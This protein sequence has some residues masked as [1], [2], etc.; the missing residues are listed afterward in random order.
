MRGV[1][2]ATAAI[3]VVNALP[4]GIG[5]AVGVELRVRAEVT[6]ERV[7]G[8]APDVEFEPAT[9]KTPLATEALRLAH[10]VFPV[11]GYDPV[12][13]SIRSAI[14][15]AQGLKSSSAV[16]SAIALAVAD[17]S[18]R[19]HGPEAVAALSARAGRAAGVSATGAFD[20]AL[21]GVSGGLVVTDNLHDRLVRVLALPPD[22]EVGLWIPP[23]THPPSPT[24]HERFRAEAARSHLA[25]EAVLRDDWPVAMELNSELV[26]RVMGYAYG[27]LRDEARRHG[28]VATGTSGL[29]PALAV[30]ASRDRL[31]AAL[32]HLPRDRAVVTTVGLSH[33]PPLATPGGV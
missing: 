11:S 31:S 33:R 1:G 10:S 3:T 20:D 5:G 15:V 12:R 22:L 30:V 4:T 19:P 2:E 21:A 6:L 32:E 16:A 7:A 14:P 27:P 24:T 29:G 9:A 8:A 25:V 17:A 28:A 26:E 23:G 13:L 18:G